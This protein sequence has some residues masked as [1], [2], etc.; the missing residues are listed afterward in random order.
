RPRRLQRLQLVDG[1]GILPV[2]ERGRGPGRRRRRAA[3]DEG[4]ADELE[5]VE[6]KG[7][8]IA[9]AEDAG[10]VAAVGGRR[11]G[12]GR[13]GGWARAGGARGGGAAGGGGL[14]GAGA[15]VGVAVVA[16]GRDA[17]GGDD[18]GRGLH[19]Q[20]VAA[21]E[22]HVAAR[23]D[24]PDGRRVCGRGQ[25][26]AAR[27]DGQ[28]LSRGREVGDR[29][30]HVA[31]G[32]RGPENDQGAADLGDVDAAA[33]AGVEAVRVRRRQVGDGGRG[34]VDGQVAGRRADAATPGNQVDAV[35]DDRG[36]LVD[37]VLAGV[38]D[39]T[40]LGVQGHIPGCRNGRVH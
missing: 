31:A 25:R 13:R 36:R 12:G 16:R 15:G 27:R 28:V 35:A 38:E 33:R 3:V 18:P 19:E 21:P 30:L 7:V 39:R 6:R 4:L 24:E 20:V 1:E 11:V 5:L 37:R 26:G 40:V 9:V 17:V 2:T 23:R 29:E 10:L 32:R 22:Q 8:V 14:G 34:R